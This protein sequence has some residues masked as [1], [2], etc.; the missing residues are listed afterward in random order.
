MKTTTRRIKA[1]EGKGKYAQI[2]DKIIVYDESGKQ[3][4][5]I[6]IEKDEDGKEYYNISN[7]KGKL[8]LFTD[9]PKDAID[10]ILEDLGDVILIITNSDFD[11]LFLRVIRYIDREYGEQLRQKTLEDWKDAKFGYAIK[12][13]YRYLLFDGYL[14]N[15]KKELHRYSDNSKILIF[16]NYNKAKKFVDEILTT[17]KKYIKDYKVFKNSFKDPKYEDLEPFYKKVENE[18]GAN[19]IYYEVFFGLLDN[20]EKGRDTFYIKIVQYPIM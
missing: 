5:C 4:D 3:I 2:V 9:Y 14:I 13:G 18:I 11:F 20:D 8:K 15:E 16:N 19:S 10:C 12:F 17:S 1:L 6:K 7:P